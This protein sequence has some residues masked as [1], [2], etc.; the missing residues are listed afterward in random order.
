MQYPCPW[1]LGRDLEEKGSSG[2]G[3]KIGV[4]TMKLTIVPFPPV[5]CTFADEIV[6][7]ESEDEPER[8]LG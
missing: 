3:Q 4:E 2:N 5:E 8:I 6:E 7:D 1:L